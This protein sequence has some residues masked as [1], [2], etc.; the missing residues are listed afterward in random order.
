[1][2]LKESTS[3]LELAIWKDNGVAM[4]DNKIKD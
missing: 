1:V 3:L 4:G 2:K